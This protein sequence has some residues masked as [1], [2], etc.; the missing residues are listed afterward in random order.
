MS[1]E[2]KVEMGHQTSVLSALLCVIIMDAVCGE[3]I[4]GLK[5]EILLADD[6]VLIT[7][8]MEMLQLKLINGRT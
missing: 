6:V 8:S 5:F 3:V 7:N 1:E 4:D 2:F